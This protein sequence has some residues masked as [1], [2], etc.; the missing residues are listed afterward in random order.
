MSPENL[1]KIEPHKNIFTNLSM[2]L[3]LSEQVDA[4]KMRAKLAIENTD[5][6]S[7]EQI[8]HFIKELYRLHGQCPPLLQGRIEVILQRLNPPVA[9]QI[10]IPTQD[11]SLPGASCY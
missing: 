9:I 6:M 5:N 10:A 3:T 7:P 11:M 1:K 2:N 4:A 8:G